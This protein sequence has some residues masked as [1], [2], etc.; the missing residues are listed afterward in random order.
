M[1]LPAFTRAS[2]QP[3]NRTLNRRW[4]WGDKGVYRSQLWAAG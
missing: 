4:L 1:Y 2:Y 3:V